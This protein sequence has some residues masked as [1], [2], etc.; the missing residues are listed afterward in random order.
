[1]RKNYIGICLDKSGSMFS[2]K[3][4]TVNAYNSNIDAIREA[5]LREGQ[6]T[7]LYSNAFGGD[8][9]WLFRNSSIAKL[10]LL[11][12]HDYIPDGGTPLFMAL[13]EMMLELRK[14]PDADDPNVAFQILVVTDGEENTSNA[15]G[16]DNIGEACRTMEELTAT[17]RWTFAFLLPRGRSNYFARKY[18]VPLGNCR[19]WDA[20]ERGTLEAFTATSQAYSSYFTARTKGMTSTR[21]FY[22]DLG[23]VKPA[24]LKAKC[25]EITKDVQVWRAEKEGIIREFCERKSGKPFLKGAAF[26][27]LTKTEK[28]VQDY[29]QIVIRDRVS[30]KVFGG[31]GARQMLGLP[32]YGDVK[33]VPGDHSQY[34]VFVQS[35]S[36]NRKLPPGSNVLYWEKV[37]V[38]YIEGVSSPWGK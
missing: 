26:Y 17:D 23:D 28:K 33:L 31:A 16:R 36:V 15:Y 5:T 35:T 24:D 8:V 38:P 25:Q 20:T 30:K 32:Q 12:E 11:T 2:I 10:Q 4:A 13:K 3:R 22:T 29:K 9:R 19:E 18:N 6:D 1:M 14:V 7:I 21:S 37:G 27:E 34:D